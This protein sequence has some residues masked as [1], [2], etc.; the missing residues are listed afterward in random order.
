MIAAGVAVAIGFGVSF[1]GCSGPETADEKR[2]TRVTPDGGFAGD[3]DT[4][5]GV[6]SL[7]LDRTRILGDYP[8]GK[9]RGE[10][11]DDG[12]L[13]F[14]YRDPSERGE[15][16]FRLAADGKTFSGKWRANGAR[17]WGDWGGSLRE[18]DPEELAAQSRRDRTALNDA[19]RARLAGEPTVEAQPPA[20]DLGE[21]DPLDP[22]EGG[23]RVFGA[24]LHG[25]VGGV[26]VTRTLRGSIAEQAGVMS[27]DLIVRFN[28]RQVVSA[29]DLQDLI[30]GA[31]GPVLVEVSRD[32]EV[33][34]LTAEFV[35]SDPPATNR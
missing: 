11:R 7:R 23:R 21:P 17:G 35:D 13:V 24:A 10:I 27:G 26:Q 5:F 20:S 14:T 29:R 15:G 12:N 32:G 16:W 9:L 28:G 1:L 33:L 2:V 4:D 18:V 3:W 19:R 8:S 31:E 34:G 22:E 30:D 6:L 25:S